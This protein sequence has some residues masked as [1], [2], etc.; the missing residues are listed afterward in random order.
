MDDVL[1]NQT[2]LLNDIKTE[3]PKKNA[4]KKKSNLKEQLKEKDKEIKDLKDKIFELENQGEKIAEI[5]FLDVDKHSHCSNKSFKL[6]YRQLETVVEMCMDYAEI[7]DIKSK[8]IEDNPYKL[9]TYELKAKQI[10]EIGN[11]VAGEIKY[12][13]SCSNKRAKSDIGGDAL[14]LLVNGYEH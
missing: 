13:K 5:Q 1:Q 2:S 3:E 8:D 7:L 14:E 12:N 4:C 10:R 6:S 11:R 9:A